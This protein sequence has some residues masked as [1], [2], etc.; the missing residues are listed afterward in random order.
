MTEN[1][2]RAL[3]QSRR[4]VFENL[5]NGVPPEKIG[6]DGHAGSDQGR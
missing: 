3:G 2:R 1:E 6:A 5:V 4:F